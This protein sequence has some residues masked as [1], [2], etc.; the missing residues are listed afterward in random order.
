[1]G[2]SKEIIWYDWVGPSGY[3]EDTNILENNTV[4]VSASSQST[5]HTKRRIVLSGRCNCNSRVAE[6]R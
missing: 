4:A 6:S 5:T 2:K 3:D 1:M